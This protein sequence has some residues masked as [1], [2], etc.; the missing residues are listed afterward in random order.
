M[1]LNTAVRADMPTRL[2]NARQ[3]APSV[4]CRMSLADNLHVRDWVR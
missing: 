1:V 2:V 4:R 3:F